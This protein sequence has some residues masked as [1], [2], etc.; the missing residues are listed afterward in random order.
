MEI[1]RVAAFSDGPAGGNPAGVVLLK[2]PLPETEMARLAAEVGYSETVFAVQLDAAGQTWRV[3]YFSPESEVPFCGHATIALGAVLGEELSLGNYQ[4]TLNDAEIRVTASVDHDGVS[5]TLASP[6][7]LSRSLREI[8][9]RDVLSLFGFDADDLNAALP[10]AYIHAG[11]NHVCVVLKDR[12]RLAEMDYDLDEGR[13]LMRA[14]D[15]ATVMLVFVENDRQFE[16]RNAFASGGVF[17]DPATGAAAAA[18]AGYLRDK[19]W[20]HGDGFTIRQGMDM[21]CPCIIKVSMTGQPGASVLVSGG[22]RKMLPP[23]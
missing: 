22:V 10:P 5:A 21:G 13:R 1:R 16:V 23:F 3:R 9:Q 19:D 8:E 11:A 12:A 14:L 17:E 6:P 2:A 18:F 20:P 7:T 15:I 4:L